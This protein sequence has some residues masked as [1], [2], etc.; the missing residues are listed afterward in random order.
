MN[1][2]NVNV[3]WAEMEKLNTGHLC[4]SGH[5]GQSFTFSVVIFS[6]L[7]LLLRRFGDR[8]KLSMFQIIAREVSK[9]ANMIP[10]CSIYGHFCDDNLGD[11]KKYFIIPLL[12]F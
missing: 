6:Q 12:I 8:S 3:D 2:I 10:G 7:C 11:D 9:L 5:T 1:S 4:H